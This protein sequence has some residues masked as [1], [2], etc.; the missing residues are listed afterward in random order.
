M[1]QGQTVIIENQNSINIDQQNKVWDEVYKQLQRIDAINVRTIS[2]SLDISDVKKDITNIKKIQEIQNSDSQIDKKQNV[3]DDKQKSKSNLTS[4][5]KKRYQNIGAQFVKG[6]GKQFEKIKKSIQ[7]KEKMKTSKQEQIVQK[8]K[9][10]QKRIK[11]QKVGGGFWKKLLVVVG[12]LGVIAILFRDKIAN[13]LP[14]LSSG[15]ESLG[16]KILG[17]FTGLV[18]TLISSCVTFIGGGLSGIITYVCTDILPGTIQGFFNDTLPMAMVASTLAVLSMFSQGAGQ[19][20]SSLMGSQASDKALDDTKKADAQVKGE[21]SLIDNVL[22]KSVSQLNQQKRNLQ[23]TRRMYANSMYTYGSGEDGFSDA[24]KGVLRSLG[25]L[26]GNDNLQEQIKQDY[27]DLG[28]FLVEVL[29][30]SN[31]KN[32]SEKQKRQEYQRLFASYFGAGVDYS[33]FISDTNNISLLVQMANQMSANRHYREISNAISQNSKNSFNASLGYVSSPKISTTLVT[34]INVQGA[35]LA[36]VADKILRVVS[37]IQKFINGTKT[38]SS[39]LNKV[40]QFF[41]VLSVNCGALYQQYAHILGTVLDY[42]DKMLFFEPQAGSRISRAE[43]GYKGVLLK[44]P[45]AEVG[46][47]KGKK[48]KGVAN[49]LVVNVSNHHIAG[50]GNLIG[51][52]NSKTLS[53]TDSVKSCIKVLNQINSL[54]ETQIIIQSGGQGVDISQFAN[55]V[56]EVANKVTT[57]QGKVTNLEKNKMDKPQGDSS[58]DK[59]LPKGA[60]IGAQ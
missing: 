26:S 60:Q 56:G 36:S 6:A 53:I 50:V 11:K 59:K 3:I 5:Q 42:A 8:V 34:K 18:S 46:D 33:G 30:I 40:G 52:I 24:S 29:K 25:K 58:G 47:T 17:A 12:I 13:L 38:N 23:D 19:Q 14:D 2:M 21:K 1:A 44:I 7:L 45:D 4:N 31:S 28:P 22:G 55:S 48:Y 32:L 57:L 20:L 9:T 10:T 54:V 43:Q 49:T 35:I 37:G 27:F 51:G 41:Q 39:F 16:E 15:T